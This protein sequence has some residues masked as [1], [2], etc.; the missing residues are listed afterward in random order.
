MMSIGGAW[1]GAGDFAGVFRA[2][3]GINLVAHAENEPLFADEQTTPGAHLDSIRETVGARRAQAAVIPEQFAGRHFDSA[4]VSPTE[5][6]NLAIGGL[7]RSC[8]R[9]ELV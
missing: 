7:R 4:R 1:N 3:F 5:A 8:S 6:L 2:R 9:R